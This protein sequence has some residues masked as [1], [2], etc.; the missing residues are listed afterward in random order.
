MGTREINRR[1]VVRAAAGV[2]AGGVLLGGTGVASASATER[3]TAHGLLGSWVLEH[4]DD[5]PAPPSPGTGVVS[6]APGG[7]IIENDI[8]PEA[9]VRS[10]SWA[11]TG[12]STFKATLWSAAP[13]EVGVSGATVRVRVAG[14]LRDDTL[15]GTAAITGFAPDGSEMFSGTGTFTATRLSA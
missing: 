3:H 14:T 13:P 1:Q 5:P 7:A 2:A 9:G 12:R 10:G 11:M 4:R 6:F 8:S 15:S